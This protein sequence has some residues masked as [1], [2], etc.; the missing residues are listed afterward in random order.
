[1][2]TNDLAIRPDIHTDAEQFIIKQTPAGQ[3]VLRRSTQ[4]TDK[5]VD[6]QSETDG[7]RYVCRVYNFTA[8]TMHY[9]FEMDVRDINGKWVRAYLLD[10]TDY[11]MAYVGDELETCFNVIVNE[12]NEEHAYLEMY[13]HDKGVECDFRAWAEGRESKDDAEDGI[14]REYDWNDDTRY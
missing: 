1:M 7:C 6:V 13:T 10:N 8:N 5:S 11:C 2:N 3:A 9:I 12:A 4:D 14:S